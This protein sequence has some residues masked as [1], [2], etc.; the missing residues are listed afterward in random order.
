MLPFVERFRP[1][2]EH[3]NLDLIIPEVHERLSEEELLAYAGKFD[4]T[5]CGDDRYTRRV[6]AVCTPRLKVISKWG[7]GI[8]SIDLAAAAELGVMVGN[9]PKYHLC[10]RRRLQRRPKSSRVRV[11]QL[12]GQ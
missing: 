5:I 4:G 2:F 12:G 3:Y 1:V 8:D 11:Q 10:E 6:L 9:T 7:T